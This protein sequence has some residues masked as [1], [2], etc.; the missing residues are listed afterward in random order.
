MKRVA[1]LLATGFEE[2]EAITPIDFLRR[3]GV[4]VVVTGIGSSVVQGA[5]SV[6]IQTDTTIENLKGDLDGIVIPGGMPGSSNVAESKE[7]SALIKRL[8][9]DG[10]LVAAICAAPAVVLSPLGILD[11]KKATCYPGM[12]QGFS[13]SVIFDDH[14]VVADGNIITS[15]GPGTAGEFALALVQYLEGS[16][17]AKQIFSDT[18]Q[19]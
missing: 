6:R 3:A 16:E 11:G 2:V 8:N 17:K 15:K 5:N 18:I 12:D 14:R 13:A 1:V 7:A 9:R 19:K 4:E 10:K